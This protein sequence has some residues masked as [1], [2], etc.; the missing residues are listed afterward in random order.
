MT[1]TETARPRHPAGALRPRLALPRPR[2]RL[3]RRQ[4]ARRGGLRRQARRLVRHAGQAPRPR[5]LLPAHGRRPHPGH[6][7]GR[8]DR[9]PVP[10]L[11]LG[12]RR[13][14]QG[15][16]L[17]PPGAAAGPH[18]ALRQRR[19]QRPADDLAR[20]RG[21]PGRPGDPAAGARGHRHRRV[22]RLDLERHR[23]R[24]RALPRDHRQ[25]R[26]HGALLLHPLRLPDELPQR[27]R[28][29]HGHPVHGVDRAPGHEGGGVRRR[30]PHPQ[31]GGHLLRAVVHDQLARHRLQGLPD[32]GHPD[33][34]PRPDRRRTPSSCSTACASRSPRAS[35]R[36][37]PTT[38][39]RSTP[40]CSA[41][42]SC[43]TWPSG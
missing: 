11:A 3:H 28:G 29:P 15:D 37:P 18:P 8:R 17:R 42:A 39:A 13:Q 40:T 35:T 25:R 34:L 24:Q 1:D 23:R 2:G 26:R 30:G 6:R 36:R 20:R 7:Q 31:V 32:Q 38:S 21:Q 33:Q 4:A 41:T 9:L 10:R 19:P 12:R 16:P 22:H 5:R 43:R 14:V 27:L